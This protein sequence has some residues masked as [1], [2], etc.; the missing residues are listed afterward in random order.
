MAELVEQRVRQIVSDI[1]DVSPAEIDP[2]VRFRDFGATSIDFIE[3]ITALETE[4]DVEISDGE[5]PEL[6]T[7]DKLVEFLKARQNGTSR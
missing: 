6:N 2:A 5:S 1:L 7:V 3:I 4:F